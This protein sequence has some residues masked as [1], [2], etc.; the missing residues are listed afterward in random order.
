[1]PGTKM[2]E[3]D[4]KHDLPVSERVQV[5]YDIPRD[6]WGQSRMA[7]VARSVSL[8][9]L[10][11]LALETKL[12]R[13]T[14]ETLDLADPISGK[15]WTKAAGESIERP[16]S[17]PNFALVYTSSSRKGE[18]IRVT[19][20]LDPDLHADWEAAVWY[21]IHRFG[22]PSAAFEEALREVVEAPSDALTP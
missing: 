21:Q 2:P 8:T 16:A 9:K 19:L 20:R 1:M 11:G 17:P 13:W 6:L 15:A 10:Y 18:A 22:F 4:Y 12:E 14:S 7:A 5:T 3:P